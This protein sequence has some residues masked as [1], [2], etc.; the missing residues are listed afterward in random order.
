M[1]GRGAVGDPRQGGSDLRRRGV[2]D[3][4][5]GGWACALARA[6]RHPPPY[7]RARHA[8]LHIR[9]TPAPPGALDAESEA[10]VQV[11]LQRLCRGRTTITIA[12]RL[13]TIRSADLVAVLAGG[14]V[15]ECGA[16]A[17]LYSDPAS[18][19]RQLVDK[20]LVLT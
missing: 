18:L 11:A 12:H 17:D 13:S 10:E 4:R 7:E 19:F 1:P 2:G 15:A 3:P 16:F 9:T 20:Q 6:P 8:T 14:R 5:A